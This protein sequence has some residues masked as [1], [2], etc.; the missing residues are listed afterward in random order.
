MC[1]ILQVRTNWENKIKKHFHSMRNVA[2]SAGWRFFWEFLTPL[3]YFTVNEISSL[4]LSHRDLFKLRSMDDYYCA[5][6]SVYKNISICHHYNAYEFMFDLIMNWKWV[7]FSFTGISQFLYLTKTRTRIDNS[8]FKN[9]FLP[10]SALFSFY[11]ASML[12]DR[13]KFCRNIPLKLKLYYVH[14]N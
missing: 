2:V 10:H 9:I 4:S 8:F 11:C 5:H 1:A 6:G 3:E 7:S 14:K 12:F 13:I